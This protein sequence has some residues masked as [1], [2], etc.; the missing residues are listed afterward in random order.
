MDRGAWWATVHGVTKS[1][2]G[3][4][5]HT[6]THTH[7]HTGSENQISSCVLSPESAGVS[8]SHSAEEGI[9]GCRNKPGGQRELEIQ[10]L[11]HS[12]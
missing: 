11:Q 10:D 6:H 9:Q 4:S 12:L 8:H 3:L 5:P 1:Q 2:T 7:T